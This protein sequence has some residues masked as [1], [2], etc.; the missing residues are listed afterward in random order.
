MRGAFSIRLSQ[1][2]IESDFPKPPGTSS[3]NLGPQ[4]IPVTPPRAATGDATGGLKILKSNLPLLVFCSR[5]VVSY[6]LR[7]PMGRATSHR[8]LLRRRFLMF[9][10][11]RC[12]IIRV[13]LSV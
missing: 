1:S 4:A 5:C 3:V 2:V 10:P 6:L 11:C 12:Q 13:D 8:R 9:F 7:G